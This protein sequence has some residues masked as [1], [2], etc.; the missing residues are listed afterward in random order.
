MPLIES[1]LLLLVLSRVAGEVAERYGQPSMIGEIAAGIVLGPSVLN[2]IQVTPELRAIADLGVLLLVFLAGMEMDVHDLFGALRGRG[3]W[4]GI[5][6]FV[7]PL[8][9]GILVGHAFGL[10]RTIFLGLCIAITALPVS[11]RI[12]IDL[13]K[14]TTPLGRRIVSAAV[15]ND[16]TALLILGVVLGLPHEGVGWTEFFRAVGLVLVKAV[17]FMIC[18]AATAHAVRYSTGRLPVSRQWLTRLL[19]HLRGKETVFAVTLLFVL[20]FAGVSEVIGLH[21]VVGAFFG[22]M[23]LSHELLGRT[24]FKAVERTA[25]SV[26]M[27]FLG[28]LFFAVIGLEFNPPSLSSWALVAAVLAVAFLGKIIGG[29]GRA[30]RRSLE[31]GKL[32]VGPGVERERHHGA[33]HREHRARERIHRRATVLD[34]RAD[35]GRDDRRHSRPARPRVRASH[36]AGVGGRRRAGGRAGA[37]RRVDRRGEP[38]Q[39]PS[40]GQS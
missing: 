6:G 30:T 15:M 33:G 22:S 8:V 16:V 40:G 11:V 29:L 3:I 39:R 10:E 9:L 12:L 26:T 28:P 38:N 31:P 24:H 21:F 34:P 36:A 20:L 13:G 37:G 4:V 5:M 23:L 2:L 32:D 1:I 14:L 27:G 17:G 35:G 19:P 7:V 25:S 18:V